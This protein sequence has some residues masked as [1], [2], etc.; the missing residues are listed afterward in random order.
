MTYTDYL[1]LKLWDVVAPSRHFEE[2]YENLYNNGFNVSSDYEDIYVYFD[3]DVT[4]VITF[5]DYM[6]VDIKEAKD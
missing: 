6:A 1:C 2:V 3:D 5:E 4:L